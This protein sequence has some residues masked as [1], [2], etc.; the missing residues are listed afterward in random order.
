MP[1]VRSPPL[2]D[3][4][5]RGALVGTGGIS[6]FHMRAWRAIP[7]VEIVALADPAKGRAVELGRE[8]GISGDHVHASI[9]DLLDHEKID[10]VDIATPPHVHMENVL[11]AAQRGVHVLCQ[12]PLAASLDEASR[13]IAACDAAGVRCVVN[14]NWRWRPWYR[15]IGRLIREGTI[16]EPASARFTWHADDALPGV[17]G[18]PPPQLI[19]QPYAATQPRLIVFEWGIHLIDVLRFCFG[20]VRRVTAR[21]SRN[22]PFVV[23]EDT[24]VVE[25]ELVR[26]ITGVID[27]SWGTPVPLEGRFVRGMVEPFVIEGLAGRIELDPFADDALFVTT[28]ERGERRKARGDLSRPEAYQECFRGCQQ[29]FIESL[30]SGLPAENEAIDNWNTLATVFAAYK[31]AESGRA[32]E[33]APRPAISR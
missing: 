12:K 16:G 1:D 27:I 23:G 19:R 8:F 22:S 31:S 29:H 13:M 30:C 21:M 4:P 10:F 2:G 17:D 33:V 18:S 32:V 6:I 5:L 14:E 26:G 20:D 15:E 24:A 9:A 7:G 11:A 25:L 28:N 3:R